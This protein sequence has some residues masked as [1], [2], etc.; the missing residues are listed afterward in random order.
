MTDRPGLGHH[1]AVFR[2]AILSLTVDGLGGGEDE[3]PG[4]IVPLANNFEDERRAG[5][6]GVEERTVVAHVILVSGS[7]K[8]EVDACQGA[9]H[10]GFV[11]HIPLNEFN[12]ATQILWLAARVNPR[13]K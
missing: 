12:L 7:V 10:A 3:F 11:A 9:L 4:W 8:D 1:Q 13:L 5:N 2:A 6:V